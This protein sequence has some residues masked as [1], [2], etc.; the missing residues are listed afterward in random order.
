MEKVI[1]LHHTVPRAV[2]EIF[3]H[4]NFPSRG[5]NAGFLLGY[6]VSAKCKE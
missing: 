3:N 6:L 1:Q 4:G 5:D 2:L